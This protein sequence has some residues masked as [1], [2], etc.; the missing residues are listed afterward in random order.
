MRERLSRRIRGIARHTVP[1][2]RQIREQPYT[3]TAQ[4]RT[5][6]VLQGHIGVALRNRLNNQ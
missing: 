4:G 2:T 5:L 1:D 6:H 3:F